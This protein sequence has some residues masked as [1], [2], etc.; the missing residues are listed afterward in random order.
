MATSR[1]PPPS[2]SISGTGGFARKHKKESPF[3]YGLTN[4][5][6]LKHIIMKNFQDIKQQLIDN[7]KSNPK[8]T[9]LTIGAVGTTA[10]IAIA[11]GLTTT[12]VI[13]GVATTVSASIAT[14]VAVAAIGIGATAYGVYKLHEY[15]TKE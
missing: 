4:N 2:F 13:N 7:A 3:G 14:K 12:S 11:T 15:L 1:K 6:L 9:A 10:S 5:N 8:A